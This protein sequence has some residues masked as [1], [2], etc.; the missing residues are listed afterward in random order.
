MASKGVAQLQN[1]RRVQRIVIRDEDVA[2]VSDVLR[3][4]QVPLVA[5][6][7]EGGSEKAVEGEAPE[8]VLICALAPVDADIETLRCEGV[9][10]G[11]EEVVE[12]AVGG[13]VAV[14]SHVAL[15]HV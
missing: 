13:L 7:V 1:S 3:V 8:D 11:Q 12:L 4:V 2:S 9:D 5:E 15:G 10:A 6:G 14:G